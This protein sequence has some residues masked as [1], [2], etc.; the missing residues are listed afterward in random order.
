LLS[1]EHHTIYPRTTK[2]PK[3]KKRHRLTNPSNPHKKG[4]VVPTFD[5]LTS[6]EMDTPYPTETQDNIPNTD[7]LTP[8]TIFSELPEKER[9]LLSMLIP[10]PSQGTLICLP[11]PHEDHFLELQGSFQ[12]YYSSFFKDANQE[13]NPDIL[14]LSETK[15][16]PKSFLF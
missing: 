15:T 2:T 4:P 16:P 11:S 10:P 5:H 7:P 12:T 6:N 13:N 1:L 8:L 14:F 3:K 9:R